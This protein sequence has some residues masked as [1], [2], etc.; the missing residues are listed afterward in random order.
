MQMSDEQ[1]ERAET[2]LAVKEFRQKLTWKRVKTV[3]SALLFVGAAVWFMVAASGCYGIEM[4]DAGHVGIKINRAGQQRGVEDVPTVSGWVGYWLW[5][6]NVL[7]YPVYEQPVE[8]GKEDDSTGKVSFASSEGMRFASGISCRYILNKEDVPDFYRDYKITDLRV[9]EQRYLLPEISNAFITHAR[10]YK[11]EELIGAKA[12]EF[13]AKTRAQLDERLAKM[14]VG[15]RHLG[16][17][18]TMQVPETVRNA[19]QQNVGMAQQARAAEAEQKTAVAQAARDKAIAEGQAG[20]TRTKAEAE[21]AASRAR[22]DADAYATLERAKADAEAVR[23]MAKQGNEAIELKRIEV[24][25]TLAEKGWPVPNTIIGDV[26][27]SGFM[28]QLPALK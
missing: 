7:E 17:I 28:M 2:E 4:I 12:E 5:T 19:I 16:F 15:V 18:G 13:M 21:A 20:V 8:W 6:Q 1:R 14:H 10:E 9:F 11:A 24:M 27:G 3:C 22:T 26:K 25:R 23:L